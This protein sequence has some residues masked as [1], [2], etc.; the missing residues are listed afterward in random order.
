MKRCSEYHRARTN[1][2]F[3]AV[4]AKLSEYIGREHFGIAAGYID[5][6][7]VLFHKSK[8]N[9][10]KPDF[11]VN[12]VNVWVLNSG[13]FLYF[14]KENIIHLSVICNQRTNVLPKFDRIAVHY[15]FIIV[16]S[17]A[18]YTI[19][20]NTDRFQLIFVDVKKQVGL[21]TSSDT[22]NDFHQA[23]FLFLSA[24]RDSV[25]FLS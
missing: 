7:I 8:H 10:N 24:Y 20:R 4:P 17:K 23:V 18:D 2:D 22:S 21:A 9:I 6:N 12:P 25:F 3:I 13:S 15:A 5:V 11:I 19:V 1:A 14:V 16:Q